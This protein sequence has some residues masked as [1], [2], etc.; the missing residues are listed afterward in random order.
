MAELNKNIPENELQNENQAISEN[1]AIGEANDQVEYA[2][3]T[4]VDSEEPKSNESTKGKKNSFVAGLSTSLIAVV[5]SVVVGMTN[6]LNVGLNA[7]FNDEATQYIDGKIQYSITVEN[8][9]EKET[10]KIYLYEDG[11][12]VETYDLV[13]EENDGI[14]DGEIYVDAEKIQE[15]LDAGDNVRVE[16]RL[17]LKGMVGLNVERAFDSYVFQIDKFVSE[18]ESVDMKCQCNIDGCYHFKINYSDPLGKFENF[19]AWIEDEQGNIAV[20]EFSDDPHEEQKIFVN[21]LTSSRCKLYI[22]YL[23]NGVETFIQF[24]NNVDGSESDQKD[25]FKIINL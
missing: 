19:E 2:T 17:D 16:Y 11:E 12:I 15:K 20:C 10:L 9:T 3:A 5:A 22:K 18:I 8:L 1:S 23:E 25:N 13:D 14:I 24:S 7:T 21:D 4:E 6:L